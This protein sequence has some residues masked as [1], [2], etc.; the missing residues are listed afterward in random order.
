[1]RLARN[2]GSPAMTLAW[3]SRQQTMSRRI[4]QRYGH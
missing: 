4:C 3:Y 2:C 1:L